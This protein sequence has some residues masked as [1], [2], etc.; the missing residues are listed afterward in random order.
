MGVK[1]LHELLEERTHLVGRIATLRARY[2]AF[3]TW[4]HERKLTLAK[5]K[6]SQRAAMTLAG[7]KVSN[8]Q[9]DD[10]AHAAPEYIDFITKATNEKA[11]WIRME[12]QIDGIDFTINRGQ[13]IMR[14]YRPEMGA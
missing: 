14:M 13:A 11:D 6:A 7:A 8:D 5:I 3:G 10:L 4:D 1:P 12:A 9:L 2:G